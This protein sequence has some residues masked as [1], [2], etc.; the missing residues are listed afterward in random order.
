MTI[1]IDIDDTLTN[2]VEAKIECVEKYFKEKGLNYKLVDKA[3]YY[4]SK[5]FDWPEEEWRKF[6]FERMDDFLSSASPR[7]RAKEVVNAL[8][9]DGHK[10]VI[11]TA[12]SDD[13]HKNAYELSKNWL[14]KHGFEFDE[15]ITEA[16]NKGEVCQQKNVDV[17]I[18]DFTGNI[19]SAKK[20]N[21]KTILMDCLH[22]KDYQDEQTYRAYNWDD[23]YQIINSLA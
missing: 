16:Y 14:E 9:K 5:M 18:D 2:L 11:I 12:R 22:N 17:L 10:I 1:G 19:M 13:F 3:G 23:V 7:E 8:K 4:L 15:I 20:R 21:I 6:W